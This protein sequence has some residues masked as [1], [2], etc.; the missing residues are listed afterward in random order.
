MQMQMRGK[1]SQRRRAPSQSAPPRVDVSARKVHSVPVRTCVGCRRT[2]APGDLV[3]M[4]LVPD[5]TVAF[6]LAGGAFGRGAWTHPTE[7]CLQKAAKTTA[8]ALRSDGTPDVDSLVLALSAAAHRRAVGLI[9]A[10]HRGHHLV[11]GAEACREAFAAGKARLVILATD[12]KAAKEEAWV[13]RAA[14]DLTLVTWADKAQLGAIVGRDELAVTVVT[15]VGLA[16]SI[17]QVMAMTVPA[18]SRLAKMNH[19]AAA[20]EVSALTLGSQRRQDSEDG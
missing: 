12:A 6:D 18:A 11:L 2:G 19:L 17:L 14:A 13:T 8:R 1:P 4:V 9:G 3:R 20:E 10:A 5:G 15:D 16:Q 7:A